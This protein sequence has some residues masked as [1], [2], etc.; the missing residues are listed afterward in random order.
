MEDGSHRSRRSAQRPGSPFGPFRAGLPVGDRLPLVRRR[1]RQ[2]HLQPSPVHLASLDRRDARVARVGRVPCIRRGPQRDRAGFRLHQD[3][4]PGGAEAGVRD[5]GNRWRDRRATLRLVPGRSP[6]RNPS[7]WGFRLRHRPA[8]DGAAGGDVDPGSHALSEDPD[9]CRSSHGRPGASGGQPIG[10]AGHS[11]G[12]GSLGRPRRRS[13]GRPGKV[14][15]YEAVESEVVALYGQGDYDAALRLLERNGPH[16]ADQWERLAYWRVC[17][18]ARSGRP[19]SAID[20]LAQA[21]E[22]GAWWAPRLLETED[23]LDL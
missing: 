11:A 4:R 16:L 18:L 3:P 7:A 5:P 19:E 8:G 17:L 22:A 15:P 12:T 1:G 10:G 2:A 14:T 13:G 23:D 20:T 6:L 21:V 9:R